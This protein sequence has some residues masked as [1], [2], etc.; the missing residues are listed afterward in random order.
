MAVPV[1]A[2]TFLRGEPPVVVQHRLPSAPSGRVQDGDI[3]HFVYLEQIAVID[4]V[5]H[6]ERLRTADDLVVG[7]E[8]RFPIETEQA[9]TKILLEQDIAS[10]RLLSD[11][12]V[13]Q[14]AFAA[15]RTHSVTLMSSLG[16]VIAGTVFVSTAGRVFISM[17]EM[18]NSRA[19]YTLIAMSAGP[20]N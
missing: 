3:F 2:S 1:K 7:D 13:G 8:Y 19:E 20:G 5:C 10:V 11:V 17:P 9:R 15:T 18:A 12:D 16:Q 4:G 14:A 6:K